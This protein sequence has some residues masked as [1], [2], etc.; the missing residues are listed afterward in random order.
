MQTLR[1]TRAARGQLV[2]GMV[3]ALCTQVFLEKSCLAEASG[4]G[5]VEAANQQV[6]RGFMW[7]L[8]DLMRLHEAARLVRSLEARARIVD[9]MRAVM[10]EWVTPVE[11]A[12][13]HQH[14]GK[15]PVQCSPDASNEEYGCFARAVALAHV[16]FGLA[17]ALL[18]Y[19]GAID[20]E[21]SC[22]ERLM[23]GVRDA[24]L[25]LRKPGNVRD[26]MGAD[27]ARVAETTKIVR[28]TIQDESANW[29][30]V[31]RKISYMVIP[32]GSASEREGRWLLGPPVDL[33]SGVR[34]VPHGRTSPEIKFYA[35]LA[36]LALRRTLRKLYT[37]KALSTDH[38]SVCPDPRTLHLPEG[39][40]Q[41]L[42]TKEDDLPQPFAVGDGL[43]RFVVEVYQLKREGGSRGEYRMA[44]FPR[45]CI[46][47][48]CASAKSISSRIAPVRK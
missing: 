1:R 36:T 13:R 29:P 15:V 30:R 26:E 43:N 34:I 12:A 32:K 45:P 41:L 17:K 6:D 19:S 20:D 3:A 38:P 18:G 33:E 5:E 14:S 9:R 16:Y 23:P 22:A 25:L 37:Y 7:A 48:H 40:Y 11:R 24:Q 31:T 42:S 8:N 2:I 10:N 4:E 27:L 44:I 46:G 39:E 47:A 35:R 28:E 21:L